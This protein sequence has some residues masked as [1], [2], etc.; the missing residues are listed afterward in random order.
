MVVNNS[1]FL[2]K[3]E[4]IIFEHIL[5]LDGSGSYFVMTRNKYTRKII[6]FLVLCRK[7]MVYERSGRADNWQEIKCLKN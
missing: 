7:K 3:Y 1:N 4:N 6:I 5:I 2:G